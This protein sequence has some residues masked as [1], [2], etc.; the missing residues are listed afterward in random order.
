MVHHE[1]TEAVMAEA[2][3]QVNQPYSSMRKI[4]GYFH[5][6]IA[7]GVRAAFG[8]AATKTDAAKQVGRHAVGLVPKVLAFAAKQ[9][10]VVG[11]AAG[12]LVSTGGTEAAKK[13]CRKSWMRHALPR[14]AGAPWRAPSP[15]RK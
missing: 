7:G 11:S 14:C 5:N 10:P 15:S 3:A 4:K 6:K 2:H 13:V 8:A 1:I 9:I 12:A